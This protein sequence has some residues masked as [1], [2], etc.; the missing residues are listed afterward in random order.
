MGEDKNLQCQAVTLVTMRV[1]LDKAR[2]GKILLTMPS[3]H[4]R[5]KER[6]VELDMARVGKLLLTMPSVHSRNNEQGEW[7]SIRRAWGRWRLKRYT[8][9]CAFYVTIDC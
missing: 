7:S 9:V 6:R 4:S 2:V 5:D 3:F 8:F 1:G